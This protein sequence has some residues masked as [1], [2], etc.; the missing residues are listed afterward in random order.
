MGSVLIHR[1][2]SKGDLLHLSTNLFLCLWKLDLRMRILL[3]RG[4][5]KLQTCAQA[6]IQG[7]LPYLCG[8]AQTLHL[9]S[10]SSSIVNLK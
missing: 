4:V 10:L 6:G 7:L 5:L 9:I 3:C 1:S 8:G 2:F